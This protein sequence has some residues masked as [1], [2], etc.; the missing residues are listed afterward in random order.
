MTAIVLA[1]RPHTGTRASGRMLAADG[2]DTE[3]RVAE[4]PVSVDRVARVPA[5]WMRR[6]GHRMLVTLVAA[7]DPSMT[8]RDGHRIVQEISH[9]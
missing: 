5:I 7:V 1:I 6:H 8:L 2:P 3:Y 9:A 4:V